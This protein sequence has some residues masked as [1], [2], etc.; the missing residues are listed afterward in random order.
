MVNGKSKKVSVSIVFAQRID[1]L[2]CDKAAALRKW[3]E[4][5]TGF[6]SLTIGPFRSNCQCPPGEFRNNHPQSLLL[7][8]GKIAGGLQD[9]VVDFQC[10]SHAPNVNTFRITCQSIGSFRVSRQKRWQP[11]RA[12][13]LFLHP[14]RRDSDRSS[15]RKTMPSF[16]GQDR[17][18]PPPPWEFSAISPVFLRS[19]ILP[20]ENR[21]RHRS[22]A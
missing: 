11:F 8:A 5:Q 19:E 21:K 2:V 4:P 15:K 16:F 10:G 20:C 3:P 14:V 7:A 12:E 13:N 9:I 1:G 6:G 17:F 18:P 22:E